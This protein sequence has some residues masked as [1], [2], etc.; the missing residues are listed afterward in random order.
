MKL[1]KQRKSSLLLNYNAIILKFQGFLQKDKK[2]SVARVFPYGGYKVKSAGKK[3]VESRLE[4][5]NFALKSLPD[6]TTRVKTMEE[7]QQCVMRGYQA[8]PLQMPVLLLTGNVSSSLGVISL[9]RRNREILG[10][11]RIKQNRKKNV[12]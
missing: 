10:E 12:W 7:L 6:E 4:A 5:E 8:E 11:S 9:K 3:D 2:Y 1:C